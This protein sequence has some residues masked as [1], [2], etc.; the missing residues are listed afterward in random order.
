M[1]TADSSHHE[2]GNRQKEQGTGSGAPDSRLSEASWTG[3]YPVRTYEIDAA[4]RLSVV[5]L[6]NYLQDAA[7]NHAHELGLSIHDLNTRNY[8]WVLS[9][10]VVN[11]K[12]YPVWKDRLTVR[13]WPSGIHRLFALRDFSIT[14]SGGSVIGVAS[15]GWLVIDTLTRRPVR[16]EPFIENLIVIP[17]RAVV[18][19]FEKLPQPARI[20]NERQFNVRYGDLDINGHVNNVSYIG[21]TIESV[22]RTVL[23]SSV[24]SELEIDYLAE[25]YLGDRVIAR[26]GSQDGDRV[27][28]LHSLFREGDGQ[29]IVRA[30]TVWMPSKK[31]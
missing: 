28:F 15:S 11:M 9:R 3:T 10:L 4:G 25:T 16:I 24:L 17:D 19:S 18:H 2:P 26:S 22:P 6:C 23:E 5:S 14:D 12:Q 13:T 1:T 30:R 20:D 7:G 21:W 8:T 31:P 29:E 27:S